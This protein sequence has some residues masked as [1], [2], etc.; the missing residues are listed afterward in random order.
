[1][2]RSLAD[3]RHKVVV[4][5]TKP[6]NLAAPTVTELTAGVDISCSIMSTG[7]TLGPTASDTVDEK[8]L[9]EEGNTKV[10]TTANFEGSLTLFRYFDGTT[11]QADA[12]A[13][14]AFAALNT[15][16]A[17]VWIADRFTAKKSAE[18]FTALDEVGVYEVVPDFAQNAEATGYIKKI[19]PLQVNGNSVPN[20]VV[21]GP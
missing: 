1:M 9:C 17:T 12:A 19:V 4:M 21:A 13:D 3:G 16:G 18:A 7:Y 20:A 15:R 5:S 2:P 11:K 14:T 6:A 8:A 10:M